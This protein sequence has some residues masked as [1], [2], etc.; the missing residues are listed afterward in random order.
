MALATYAW[1]RGLQL[2]APAQ[3]RAANESAVLKLRTPT[4]VLIA[5]LERL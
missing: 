4:T 2:L 5:E 3:G 1:P